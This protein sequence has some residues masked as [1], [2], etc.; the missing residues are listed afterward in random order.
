MLS[1]GWIQNGSPSGGRRLLLQAPGGGT[2]FSTSTPLRPVP[3]SRRVVEGRS[4]ACLVV[5]VSDLAVK[6]ELSGGQGPGRPGVT[7][8]SA[9][10]E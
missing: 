7:L 9:M 1:P 8:D 4:M 2:A 5:R 3:G 10:P 6:T